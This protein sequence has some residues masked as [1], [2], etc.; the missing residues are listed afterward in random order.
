M[1]KEAPPRPGEALAKTI[2]GHRLTHVADCL[3]VNVSTLQRVI[4]GDF[5]VT[6]AMA[7][8]LSIALET[9]M[10]YWLRIQTER[11][12]HAARQKP[13]D[14]REVD[15]R[16]RSLG[17][18]RAGNAP[19]RLGRRIRSPAPIPRD[20]ARRGGISFARRTLPSSPL[21]RGEAPSPP[22]PLPGLIRCAKHR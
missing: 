4:R 3:G 20:P 9:P 21:R 5:R 8:R 12:G 17:H 6:P 22:G 18:S 10:E 19:L 15:L 16:T 7:Y 1:L 2:S 11:L 14:E 13:S